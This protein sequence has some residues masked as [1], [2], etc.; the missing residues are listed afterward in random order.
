MK[1]KLQ[2][3]INQQSIINNTIKVDSPILI[4]FYSYCSDINAG[5]YNCITIIAVNFWAFFSWLFKDV[6][7]AMFYL[8]FRPDSDK[9]LPTLNSL[10]LML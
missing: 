2:K 7:S 3:L 4:G 10:I 6:E 8:L 5:S 9:N 1:Q